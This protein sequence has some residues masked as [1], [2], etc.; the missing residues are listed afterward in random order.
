MSSNND[1]KPGDLVKDR[2][3]IID[4]VHISGASALY[5]V[6]D[7]EN[8]SGPMLA[9]KEGLIFK[10][11]PGEKEEAQS[12]FNQRAWMLLSIDYPS[13]QHTYDF[14]IREE[15]TYLVSEFIEG[16]DLESALANGRRYSVPQICKWGITIAEALHYLHTRPQPIIYRDLKP[17]N[18]MLTEKDQVFLV[19]FDIAGVFPQGLTLDPL[20]TD[21][22]AAPEQYRG[23]VNPGIDIYGL[24]AT[25][26]H[27]LSGCDP[28]VEKPFSF[29]ERSLREHNPDVTDGL[30]VAI[31]VA[32][33]FD[34]D[35]RYVTA[36]EF[37][38]ALRR[39]GFG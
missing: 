31:Q 13:I 8:Q 30:D 5:R 39:L 28:R 16:S 10:D 25:L 32:V 24:G 36:Q 19:D 23:V 2:Y 34:A 26:H 20:G 15:R 22:Y 33:A 17:A 9:L 38:Q 6:R 18:L 27:L 37:A 21:G 29:E 35:R 14:F 4:R 12:L 3:E 1:L 7:R 11:D